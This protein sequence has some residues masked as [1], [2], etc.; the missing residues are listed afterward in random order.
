MLINLLPNTAYPVILSVTRSYEFNPYDTYTQVAWTETLG[1]E[2]TSGWSTVD[3]NLPFGVPIGTG[4]V[5]WFRN[6]R[7]GRVLQ[8][9]SLPTVAEVLTRPL[10][11]RETPALL[12]VVRDA[13]L[14][15]DT[16]VYT[17]DSTRENSYNRMEEYYTRM[18]G[19]TSITAVNNAR[20]GLDTT[21][22]ATDVYPQSQTACIAAIPGTGASTV[23]EFSL[24]INDES[25]FATAAE[26]TNL[27]FN[28]ISTVLAAK[29]DVT[30]FLVQ[31]TAVADSGRNDKL[32]TAYANLQ[33]MLN[34][35]L[36]ELYQ[37]MRDVYDAGSGNR[38]YKDSTHPTDF[39]SIRMVNLILDDVLHDDQIAS[40]RYDTQHYR[41]YVALRAQVGNYWSS[42]GSW[43]NNEYWSSFLEIDLTGLGEGTEF[44]I[45]H[46][47]IRDDIRWLPAVGE[48]PVLSQS[49]PTSGTN[50]L[51]KYVRP[52]G[53][54]G[55][56]LLVV[57]IDSVAA[58][59]VGDEYVRVTTPGYKG[60]LD[61]TMAE[62]MVNQGTR[63][64]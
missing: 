60:A 22:W 13:M 4:G 19:K 8:R 43:A 41:G 24:G 29:P 56:N 32:N 20:S 35:W 62:I 48:L 28:A 46:S 18:L 64:T 3:S 2:P 58:S 37:P 12:Q 53:A 51:Y 55:A 9:T 44:E 23:W 39:G 38:F 33:N 25:Q 49:T 6:D 45:Y 27:W 40:V 57:N 47:G 42:S 14:T 30:L 54:A 36:V 50:P 52:A 21:E 63:I 15:A 17:G 61:M 7:N 59:A 34:V 5:L 31:P 16:Y 1:P 26:L 11:L 10:V